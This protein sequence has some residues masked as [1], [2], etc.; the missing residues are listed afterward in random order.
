MRCALLVPLC[1]FILPRALPAQ[2]ESP[3]TRE[4]RAQLESIQLRLDQLRRQDSGSHNVTEIGSSRGRARQEVEPQLTVRIYDLGDL[5]SIAP[6]YSAHE[7]ADLQHVGRAVFPEG[8]LATASA[9]G[10]PSAVG[11]MG[12]NVSV[13]ER[14]AVHTATP[15]SGWRD[16]ATVSDSARTSVES[17]VDTI[18]TT[19]SP[20]QWDDVG[21]PASITT[22]GA[23][24]IVSAPLDT[25]DKIG[26]LLDLFRKR[27]RSLRTISIEAHW[28]W[29][30]ESELASAPLK[31]QN[32]VAFG[33]L[34]DAAW[35]KLRETASA[36]AQRRSAYHAV[37]TCYNGQTVHALAGGQRVVVAGMTPVV[38]GAECGSAS[39][40]SSSCPRRGSVSVDTH[41]DADREIW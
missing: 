16:G 17:L 41:R 9:T 12:A 14:Y 23:S 36:D 37:L 26:A 30:T 34:S 32:A 2:V 1:L 11:G 8:E 33:V 18:T 40:A 38:G 20:D 31:E 7:P 29:L 4:L 19:I 39:A 21:G 5:Y 22:L 15:V 35:K 25:H 3:Q 10:G 13:L 24:L 27:W 28:L 6:S